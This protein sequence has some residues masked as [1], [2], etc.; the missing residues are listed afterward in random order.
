M[1][2]PREERY[3][4]AGSNVST[5]SQSQPL[6]LPKQPMLLIFFH[7]MVSLSLLFQRLNSLLCRGWGGML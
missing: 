7:W 2:P 4:F 3:L 5:E 1:S 6:F